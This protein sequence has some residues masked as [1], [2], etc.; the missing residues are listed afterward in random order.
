M[1]FDVTL[2]T[3]KLSEKFSCYRLTIDTESGQISIMN[4]H[5][6]MITSIKSGNVIALDKD[7]KLVRKY[8]IDSGIVSCKNGSC[9]IIT[10]N[11]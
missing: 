6:D 1:D 5:A 4:Q 10:S 8:F 3:H 11:I 9:T 7:E 2:V